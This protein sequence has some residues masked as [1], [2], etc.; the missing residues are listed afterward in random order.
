M[1]QCLLAGKHIL[2]EKPFTI[3]VAQAKALA[4][5]AREKKRF[6]MEGAWTR[7]FPLV[8]KLR[9]VVQGGEIGEVLRIFSDHGRE[10]IDES[11]P[12]TSRFVDMYQGAGGFVDLGRL[13]HRMSF[14]VLLSDADVKR[15]R[16]LCS[17]LELSASVSLERC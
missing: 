14:V 9:E 15:G 5:L 4:T 12:S 16:S 17:D 11:T 13:L 7:F 8:E 2:C 1:K 6:L 10:L 3:N